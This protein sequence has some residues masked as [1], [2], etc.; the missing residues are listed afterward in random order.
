M[1]QIRLYREWDG[2]I[3]KGMFNKIETK[4]GFFDLP[5]ME[6]CN[7]PEHTPPKH[8]HIPQG[9]GYKHICPSCGKETIIIP[10]QIKY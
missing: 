5:K 4:G 3:P 2:E 6:T 8:L 1:I 7:H 9:K 10:P